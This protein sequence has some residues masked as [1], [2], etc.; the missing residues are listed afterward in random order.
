MLKG[1]YAGRKGI[2]Q[3]AADLSNTMCTYMHACTRTYVC[4]LTHEHMQTS[5]FLNIFKF[6]LAG[7]VHEF[8]VSKK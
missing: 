5:T 4:I 3:E 2:E 8:P 6:F 1:S 7:S